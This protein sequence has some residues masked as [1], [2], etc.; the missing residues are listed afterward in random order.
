MLTS[1]LDSETLAETIESGPLCITDL[2]HNMF[3]VFML[4]AKTFKKNTL[5][6]VW[7]YKAKKNIKKFLIK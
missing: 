6:S 7:H 2:F 4:Y 3:F 5:A 1:L